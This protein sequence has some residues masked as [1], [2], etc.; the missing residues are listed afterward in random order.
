M[1]GGLTL[2]RLATPERLQKLRR[3]ALPAVAVLSFLLFL[4]ITFPYEMIARRIETEAQR[5][6]ADLTIGSIGGH[7]FF[8]VRARNVRVR[9]PSSSGEPASEL[10]F[11]RVDVSPDL[12]ALLLRRTSF[13]FRLEGYGGSA[14]GHAALS[15]DP[16]APG[17]QSL[18]LSSTDLDLRASP[19]KDLTG[20]DASGRATLQVDVSSMQ[21]PEGA[22]G[23][24]SLNGR[25]LAVAG[26]TVKGFTLPRAAL[27]DL[28]V[29]VTIDKGVARL[30]RTQARGGD[31]DLEA[32]GT[33][34][35]RALLALSQA[36]LHVRLRPSDRWLNDN[37][38]IKGA[39]GLVQNARQ[40]DGSYVFSFSGP[41]SRLNSRPGR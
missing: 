12:F 41:L 19:L 23:S 10:R 33:V 11:D 6:G 22:A 5:A 4:L 35:L 29:A 25:Q 9:L 32:D 30:D 24:L 31:L 20:I 14:S 7:G 2:A 37:A 39:L 15:N 26:G 27:G 36:D 18:R 8:G 40:P 16:R 34:R 28:D 38:F 13:A 1:A 17:L 21:P 3:G